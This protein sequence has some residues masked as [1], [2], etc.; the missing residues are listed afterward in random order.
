M[1]NIGGICGKIYNNK[2]EI[3]YSKYYDYYGFSKNDNVYN[4]GKIYGETNVGGICGSSEADYNI[5][6]TNCY[7][8][9]EINYVNSY[10]A[11]VGT[12]NGQYNSFINCYYLKDS[13][14][15]ACASV[16]VRA[17]VL[18]AEQ[19]KQED[20]FS[21]FNFNKIWIIDNDVDMKHPQL[22]NNMENPAE[23]ISIKDLP[24]KLTYYHHDKLDVSGLTITVK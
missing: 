19:M 23:E 13:A 22:R 2:E 24:E 20:S 15:T 4:A 7:N 11:I 1:E 17:K 9:G 18:T 12:I 6:Y 16:N 8:S 14:G 3:Y 10:G 21:G 5:S